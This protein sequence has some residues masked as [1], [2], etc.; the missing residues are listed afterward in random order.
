MA[1]PSMLNRGNVYGGLVTTLGRRVGD[2]SKTI[3]EVGLSTRRRINGLITLYN[4]TNEQI[5]KE[6][7]WAILAEE[8]KLA[9]QLGYV[10]TYEKYTSEKSNS[11]RQLKVR[12]LKEIKFMPEGN[13]RSESYFSSTISWEQDWWTI[14]V[15]QHLLERFS[16]CINTKQVYVAK[17]G[18]T[19]MGWKETEG[20]V[21]II[22]GMSSE[23][24]IRIRAKSSYSPYSGCEDYVYKFGIDKELDNILVSNYIYK[25]SKYDEFVSNFSQKQPSVSR[26]MNYLVKI[27]E[28]S[29]KNFFNSRFIWTMAKDY[30]AK[31]KL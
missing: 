4:D 13:V 30:N 19:E 26:R 7:L 18:V 21:G 6:F 17:E 23:K 20:L 3:E 12:R 2:S 11:S 10:L 29:P 8:E 31:Y 5:E 25:L 15:P 9:I 16:K 14:Y 27:K 24:G 22:I 28:S 1:A